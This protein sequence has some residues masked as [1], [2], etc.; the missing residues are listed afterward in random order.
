LP[1][2][3]EEEEEEEAGVVVVLRQHHSSRDYL[4]ARLSL[5]VA[6][7]MIGLTCS[8]AYSKP[9]VSA[10]YFRDKA[11]GSCDFTIFSPVFSYLQGSESGPCSFKTGI[12]LKVVESV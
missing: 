4:P 1:H 5:A 10:R 3:K 11:K 8:H 9:I 7:F 12:P 2:E 6:R